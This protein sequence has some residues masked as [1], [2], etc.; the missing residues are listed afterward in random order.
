MR[1]FSFKSKIMSKAYALLEELVQSKRE[2]DN[3]K[4]LVETFEE[5]AK[6]LI[7]Q[8]KKGSY[9]EIES[10]ENLYETKEQLNGA[11]KLAEASKNKYDQ[12]KI[13]V[14]ELLTGLED[15]E[16]RVKIEA[17][18]E[19]GVLQEKYYTVA[20]RKKDINESEIEIAEI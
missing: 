16:Y 1:L 4:K 6:H 18:D 7:E 10:L 17:D 3:N 8:I 2:Y 20:L 9:N 14:K 13:K 19:N 15:Q 11:V 5:R 12:Q